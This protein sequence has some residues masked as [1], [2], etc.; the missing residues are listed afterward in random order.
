[1]AGM[2]LAGLALVPATAAATSGGSGTK[3]H[4]VA[5]P[6][7]GNGMWIWYVNQSQDGSYRRIARKARSHGVHVIYV[8]SSDGSS[9][10][11][12][13]TPKLVSFMH[14][15]GIRVCAWQYVY[16]TF[17]GKEA[18]RGAEAVDDNADCLV[19]DAEA[20][21][22]GRYVAADRYVDALT[23]RIGHRFPLALA[24]FPYVDY[25]PSFPFSVFMGPGA[26]QFN[27][28]QLYW[29]TIGTTVA[30]GFLHTFTYNRVY[31]RRL[32]P[33]GQTYANPPLQE[34]KRFRRYALSYGFPGVSWWS[35]QET[36][37]AE[38]RT[39]GDRVNR[40]DGFHKPRA[41][42]PFLNRGDGGDL[43]IWAQEL[44]RGAGRHLRVNGHFGHKTVRAVKRFQAKEKID[45][46]GAIAT[47]TWRHLLD[48]SPDSVDWSRRSQ[49]SKTGS[50]E[51]A[52]SSLPAIDYELPVL[53][54]AGWDARFGLP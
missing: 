36:G 19:I 20:E 12:Q 49:R 52:S 6:F 34:I 48:Y 43:V 4:R 47:A 13:F 31:K 10:W 29:H 44:L 23:A 9:S 7:R 53:G 2:L 24:G 1:V 11:D 40:I 38:W 3:P 41:A 51:P 25:H 30:A 28:P 39:V 22:E 46:T 35:W 33:L 37:D 26:A 5:N 54:S 32:M 45:V 15:R 8:K 50:G 42:Y 17:P 14:D 18:A 21:Y 16:G 27:L